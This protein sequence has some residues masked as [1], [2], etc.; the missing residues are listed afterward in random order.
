M[1]GNVVV[2]LGFIVRHGVRMAHR[3]HLINNINKTDPNSEKKTM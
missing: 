2:V 1:H 3:P